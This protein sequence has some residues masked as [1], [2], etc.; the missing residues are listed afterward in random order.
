MKQI[1]Y[2][3]VYRDVYEFHQRNTGGVKDWDKVASEMYAISAKYPGS[4]F[5]KKLL[6][7]VYL[8]LQ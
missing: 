7:A 4:T 1:D 8:E 5:V 2:K 3:A 6:A